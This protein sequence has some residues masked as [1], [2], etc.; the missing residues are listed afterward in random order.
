VAPIP[1]PAAAAEKLL[2][3][4][5]VSEQVATDA[6]AAAVSG[7]KALSQ[8]AY[9]IQIAKVAVKRAIMQAAKGRA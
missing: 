7:S 8:N 2:A 9:K 3:G 6:G 5:T 4:K 1:W